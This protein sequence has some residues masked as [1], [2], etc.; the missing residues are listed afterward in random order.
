MPAKV[1][2]H[3]YIYIYMHMRVAHDSLDDVKRD[4][5]YVKIG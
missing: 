5:T 3:I 1:F 2:F 4:A